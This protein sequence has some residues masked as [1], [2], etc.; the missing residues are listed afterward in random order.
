M[1]KYNI[2]GF[3][4]WHNQERLLIKNISADKIK[5]W[6]DYCE[7]IGWTNLRIEEL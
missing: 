6:S 1:K 4:K 2:Y 3:G 7:G 5:Y